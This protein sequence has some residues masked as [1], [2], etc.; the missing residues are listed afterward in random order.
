MIGMIGSILGALTLIAALLST[1]VYLA[2]LKPSRC[3]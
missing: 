1:I 2:A 3:V